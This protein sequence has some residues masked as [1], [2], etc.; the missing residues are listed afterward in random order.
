M[1]KTIET[2]KLKI[3]FN[4]I[5]YKDKNKELIDRI[6]AMAQ[7]IGQSS[8]RGSGNYMVVSSEMYDRL[9]NM[10]IEH[11]TPTQFVSPRV[12]VRE[13]DTCFIPTTETPKM[14][15]S[16]YAPRETIMERYSSTTINPNYY[17]TII[18]S[19]IT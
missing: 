13:I 14:Y 16:S 12:N 19:G 7:A 3:R 8:R 2:K 4:S 9:Q 17:G 10:E 5:E 18:T 1:M 6:I 11:V 15:T